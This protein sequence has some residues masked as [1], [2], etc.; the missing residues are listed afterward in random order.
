M[1]LLSLSLAIGVLVVSCAKDPIEGEGSGGTPG[2][3][4]KT[5]SG[6][7]GSGGKTGSGG[8]TSK[9][10]ATGSGGKTGSGG[11][12]SKGGAT[13]SGGSTQTATVDCPDTSTSTNFISDQYGATSLSVSGNSNKNYYFMANWW[14]SP[15]G[16]QNE[17]I[18]GLGFTI[19]SPSNVETSNKDLPLGFPSIFIGSYQGKSTKGS[20]LPK[21]VSSLTSIPTIFTTNVDTMGTSN[22][23]ATYDVWF[24][25]GSGV[26]T[27]SNPGSGGAYL[28]VWQFKP[29]DKQPRGTLMANGSI[30][31]GVK[32]GWDVWYDNTNPP[33]V[34]YVASG[35]KADLQFD[36]M[37][38]IQDAINNGYGVKSSQYLSIIFAGFEVWGGGDGLQVKKFCANVK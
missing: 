28:M 36:L 26:V 14:G 22:Y 19:N 18:E 13:G 10:G 34:S 21:A 2:S 27:G 38:F 16:G 23:N 6:G 12:T 8:A 31:D 9:G 30:I 1:R 4:G 3:G 37:A 11:A 33:C 32:G 20:N 15:Y 35:K 25:S 5:G 29:T 17:D 24:T 7:A